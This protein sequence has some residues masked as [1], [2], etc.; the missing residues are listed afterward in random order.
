MSLNFSHCSVDNADSDRNEWMRVTQKCR[1]SCETLRVWI[2]NPTSLFNCENI[3]LLDEFRSRSTEN[4]QSGNAGI[5]KIK[6]FSRKTSYLWVKQTGKVFFSRIKATRSLRK[7]NE[8]ASLDSAHFGHHSS[9]CRNFVFFQNV[10]EKRENQTV[11][12][13]ETMNPFPRFQKKVTKASDERMNE[14]KPT[15]YFGNSLRKH[16]RYNETN[17]ILR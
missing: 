9:H 15:I 10:E 1:W 12:D 11:K 14:Q 13:G 6:K 4:V 7:T 5:S 8:R 17:T 16:S 2:W 3:F